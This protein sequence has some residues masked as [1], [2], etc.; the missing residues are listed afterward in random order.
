[1]SKRDWNASVKGVR[2][3]LA[4]VANTDGGEFDPVV[5]SR[6]PQALQCIMN[7][8]CTTD[9]RPNAP[10]SLSALSTTPR[11]YLSAARSSEPPF[12][13]TAPPASSPL[14]PLPADR[15]LAYLPASPIPPLPDNSPPSPPQS[16][17]PSRPVQEASCGSLP[18]PAS[19]SGRL[20]AR[21]ID[22]AW[23]ACTGSQGSGWCRHREALV[24]VLVLRLEHW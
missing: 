19:R 5:R 18:L 12:R 3:R 13:D 16:Y 14:S 22:G 4:R 7:V 11:L 17:P 1:M 10:P 6:G 8:L 20:L 23:R 21:W 15:P 9:P 24:Y 2:G